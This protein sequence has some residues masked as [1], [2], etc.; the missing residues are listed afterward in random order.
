[1]V[2]NPQGK[3][4]FLS[5]LISKVKEHRFFLEMVVD[6][7]DDVE[8]C[9]GNGLALNESAYNRVVYGFSALGNTI[10]A[11]KDCSNEILSS[12]ITWKN[13]KSLDYGK[14]MYGARN[15]M[16]HDG[17][18][19]VNCCIKGKCYSGL[20]I[21]RVYDGKIIKIERPGEDIK[22]ICLSFSKGFGDLLQRRFADA[23]K[24]EAVRGVLDVDL[25]EHALR[26][27]MSEEL[28]HAF[29]NKLKADMLENKD[30]IEESAGQVQ[31]DTL[32]GVVNSLRSYCDARQAT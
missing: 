26:H 22:S 6:S 29:L 8:G 27:N 16:T 2:I 25:I 18:P 11:I 17:N 32:I 10:Q 19:V 13:I 23:F 12:K 1:M 21:E 4:Y 7:C 15:A 20:D 9:Y 3:G 14:F 24:I 5:Y 30:V 31:M 28:D